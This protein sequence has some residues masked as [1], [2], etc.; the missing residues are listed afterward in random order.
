M[1]LRESLGRTWQLLRS[2]QLNFLITTMLAAILLLV[3]YWQYRVADKQYQVSKLQMELEQT[4]HVWEAKEAFDKALA[5]A[6]EYVQVCPNCVPH[7]LIRIPL[8]KAAQQEHAAREK[9]IAADYVRLAYLGSSV[10]SFQT[11]SDY[12][13]KA[14]GRASSPFDRFFA[15]LV[16]GHVHFVHHAA[17]RQASL[18]MARKHI[19]DAVLILQKEDGTEGVFYSLGYAYA[20]LAEHEAYLKHEKESDQAKSFARDWWAKMHD[21]ARLTEKLDAAIAAAKDGTQPELGCLLRPCE[22][23]CSEPIAI[24]IAP[25]RERLQGRGGTTLP[26]AQPVPV[27][28][29]PREPDGTPTPALP[30]SLPP[31]PTTQNAVPIRRTWTDA[32]LGSR[33]RLIEPEAA[34]VDQTTAPGD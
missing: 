31:K 13:N 27:P 28:R 7:Y 11:T 3:T 4:K 22:L 32:R 30:P 25:Y 1:T 18:Q 19:S 15:Y 10:W 5:D 23:S 29:P 17:N 20:L 8:D 9:L 6:A 12:C 2:Q 26:S 34:Q 21:S 16:L 14:L 33:S 24:P